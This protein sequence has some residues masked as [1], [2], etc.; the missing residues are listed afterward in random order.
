M[1]G[2]PLEVYLPLTSQEAGLEFHDT[3]LGQIIDAAFVCKNMNHTQWN[4]MI[5]LPITYR[6]LNKSLSLPVVAVNKI[7]NF[8]EGY[9]MILS[10]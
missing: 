1:Y 7:D 5:S 4:G 3:L 6:I 9:G 8:H 2:N 10:N